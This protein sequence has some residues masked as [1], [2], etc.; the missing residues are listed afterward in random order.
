MPFYRVPNTI[1]MELLFGA[2]GQKLENVLHI[3]CAQAPGTAIAIAIAGDVISWWNSTMK[4][5]IASDVALTGI[6]M[7]SLDSS[8]GFQLEY[9]VGL[10]IF[11]TAAATGLP[12]NVTACIRLTTYQRGRAYTG[13]LFHVGMINAQT[14]GNALYSGFVAT[15]K[16]AYEGLISALTDTD[17]LPVVVS[18][19]LHGVVRTNPE[20]TTI[21]GV[22]V[23][24]Y[25]DSQRRRLTGRGR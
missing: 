3:E 25:L 6:R 7:T 15:L 8:D 10:P 1:K 18:K 20:V 13:K 19:V 17:Y 5:L 14:A 21:V 24:S 23:E 16:N 4:P 9:N 22:A 12:L 2:Q 11:G